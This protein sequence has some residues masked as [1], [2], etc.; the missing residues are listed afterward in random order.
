MPPLPRNQ[1][2]TLCSW[3]V[4]GLRS[5]INKGALNELIEN[6]IPDIM[7][8]IETKI[9]EKTIRELKIDNKFKKYLTYWNSSLDYYEYTGVGILTKY[10]PLNVTYGMNDTKDGR[11]ITLEYEY[12]YIVAV[13]SP[14]SGNKGEKLEE[15]TK[16]E[17]KF[18]NYLKALKQNDKIVIVCGTLNVA[19]QDVDVYNPLK[20]MNCGGFLYD[21]KKC[22][23][24]I[25][26]D[27][28]D[29]FRYKNPYEKKF[30]YFPANE[31]FAKIFHQG[32]RLDYFLVDDRSKQNIITSEILNQF[33]GSDHVPIKLVYRT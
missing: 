13:N 2:I 10:N 18:R 21:E 3:N 4:N 5:I 17:N 7:C 20:N 11:I 19:F 33:N 15:R 16:W 31:K 27:F 30:T 12:V 28:V 23:E 26:I 1:T 9:D 14:Y 32:E 25:L 8:I 24:N 22:F 29:C 6:Q